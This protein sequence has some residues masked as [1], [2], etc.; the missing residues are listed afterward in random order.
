MGIALL[1][2]SE[3]V[4]S[5]GL[6]G[7]AAVP[8]LHALDGKLTAAPVAFVVLVFAAAALVALAKRWT[9]LLGA[10]AAATF[11]QVFWLLLAASAGDRG[12]IADAG[13]FFVLLVGAALAQ[14]R[15]SRAGALDGTAGSLGLA[16]AGLALIGSMT[17][18]HTAPHAG[19]ALMVAASVLAAAAIVALQIRQELV[20][21]LGG[22]ALAVASVGTA[23][24]L[25]NRSLT[26][27]WAAEAVVL[28]LVGMRLGETRYRIAAVVYAALALVHVLAVEAPLDLVFERSAGGYAA[29]VPSIAAV[30]V[31]AAAPGWRPLDDR[32]LGPAWPYVQL[33]LLTVASLA[34]LD[35]VSLGV[36]EI[37]FSVGHLVVTGIWAAAGLAAV[38]V[39]SRLRDQVATTT[40]RGPRCSLPPPC[41]WASLRRHSA[42]HASET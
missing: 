34:A 11:A 36:V 10:T 20:V 42:L 7:A 38:V 13:A 16:G 35:A 31:A 21:L 3:V 29:A 32:R 17:V 24:L 5:L 14:Q 27:A 8:A 37:S 41:S 40:G 2:S 18:F 4:A 15:V 33:G 28:A 19:I 25:S 22:L 6:L 12:A 39:G 1:W 26:I 30:A 9:T 23:D